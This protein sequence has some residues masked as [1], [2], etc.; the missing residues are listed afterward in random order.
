VIAVKNLWTDYREDVAAFN[1]YTGLREL[2]ASINSLIT[3][4]EQF[5]NGITPEVTPHITEAE[6]NHAVSD[7]DS[8]YIHAHL[9]EALDILAEINPDFIGWIT[10]P[11]TT[12][13]YPTVRGTNNTRYLKTTF[14]GA[15]NSAG[16]IFMDYHN[17]ENFNAPVSMLHGH[18]MRDGSMF[19]PLTNYPDKDFLEKHPE[20]IIITKDAEQLTYKIIEVKHTDAWDSIYLYNSNNEKTAQQLLTDT[21]AEHLLI[22]ST[23]IGGPGSDERLLIFAVK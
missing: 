15:A 18:N 5:N 17:K 19:A 22:L 9:I 4:T 8:D 3:E 1:E 21:N 7:T 6:T 23:C 14:S 12:I 10:I 20:I 13:D 2:S 16:T 11:G